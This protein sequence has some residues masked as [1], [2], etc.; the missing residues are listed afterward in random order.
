MPNFVFNSLAAIV[1]GFVNIFFRLMFV[2]ISPFNTKND[3]SSTYFSAFLIAPPVPKGVFSVENI[4]L[5]PKFFFVLRNFSIRLDLYPLDIIIS[6]I[7]YFLDIL[8][9]VLSRVC[10]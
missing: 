10:C 2:I 6:V 8:L 7:P 9:H 5:H 4:I 1:F 3:S